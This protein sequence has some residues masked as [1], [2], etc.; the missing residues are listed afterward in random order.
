MTNKSKNLFY[1]RIRNIRIAFRY[2]LIGDLSVIC[3]DCGV[4]DL[5]LLARLLKALIGDLK[6]IAKCGVGQRDRRSPGYCARHISYTVVNDAF[7]YE[8]GI[9]VCRHTGGFSASALIYGD[10]YKYRT[11]L[12][13]RQI[14]SLEQLRCSGAGNQDTAHDQIRIADGLLDICIR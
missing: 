14:F 13:L 5:V 8:D 11:L 12:H 2:A 3:I 4:D 10:I 9:I 6:A 7:L 1:I